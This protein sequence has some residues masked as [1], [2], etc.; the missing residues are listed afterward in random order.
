LPYESL[1]IFYLTNQAYNIKANS[2]VF[3]KNG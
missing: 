2:K 1:H 3:R